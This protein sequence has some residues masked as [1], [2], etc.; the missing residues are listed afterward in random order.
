MTA[1]GAH[2]RRVRL[3]VF[4]RE[5]LRGEACLS[6]DVWERSPGHLLRPPGGAGATLQ[7]G[8][9]PGT[10]RGEAGG[11]RGH[12]RL[13]TQAARLAGAS[14]PVGDVSHFSA[15]GVSTDAG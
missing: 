8:R 13:R 10:I 4:I 3:T 5:V 1:R 15:G 11:R 6:G 14:S 2:F 12:S 7:L 9:R